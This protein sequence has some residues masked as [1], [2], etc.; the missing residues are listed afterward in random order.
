MSTFESKVDATYDF[1]VNRA[2]LRRVTNH[3]EIGRVIGK[4]LMEKQ[5]RRIDSPVRREKV[6]AA[7]RAVDDRSLSEKGVMLSALVTHFWDN[8]VG[9]RFF[10]SATQRGVYEGNVDRKSFHESQ[11][12]KAFSAY[13]GE[14]VPDDISELDGVSAPTGGV[15]LADVT[16]IAR[17]EARRIAREEVEN[18]DF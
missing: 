6:I 17:Q 3:E 2:S 12:K 5:Q 14:E 13:G 10:D 18:A 9:S 11:V 4:T 1:L 15:T 16:R 7:L 8:G